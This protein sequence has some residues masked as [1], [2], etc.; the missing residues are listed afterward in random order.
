[1]SKLVYIA[2][3]YTLGNKEQNVKVQISVAETLRHYGFLPYWPLCSHYWHL[4]YQHDYDFWM[5]QDKEWIKHCDLLLRLPGESKGADKEVEW[6]IELG[7]TVYF[8]IDTLIE[9][10]R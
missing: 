10:E 9:R 1:M 6:A 8:D 4:E 2:S 7:K 3:P 5:A